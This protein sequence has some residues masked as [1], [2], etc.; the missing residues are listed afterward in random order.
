MFE[1]DKPGVLCCSDEEWDN[2]MAVLD[3]EGSVQWLSSIAVNQGE[4]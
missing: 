2:L 3:R 4:M 1:D